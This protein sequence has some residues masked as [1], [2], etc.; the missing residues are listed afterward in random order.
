MW[1]ERRPIYIQFDRRVLQR[2]I[3]SWVRIITRMKA[4][5]LGACLSAIRGR[6]SIKHT[7]IT[8]NGPSTIPAGCS[9]KLPVDFVGLLT[10]KWSCDVEV[11][12]WCCSRAWDVMLFFLFITRPWAYCL[13]DVR[14]TLGKQKL[15]WFFF[16]ISNTMLNV[17]SFFIQKK[18][19]QMK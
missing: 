10:V 16:F 9:R 6:L 1:T 13:D 18:N 8:S 2:N 7:E 11:M 19:I 5:H 17:M 3:Q 14:K 4:L 12:V 15:L